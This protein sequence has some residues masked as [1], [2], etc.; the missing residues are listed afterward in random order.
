MK[1]YLK[2]YSKLLQ[3]NLSALLS[4][5]ANFINSMI[6]SIGWGT[7][8]FVSVLLLTSRVN[9]VYGWTRS[10][11]LILSA[12]YN[13]VIGLFHIFFSRNFERFSTVIHYGFLDSILLKPMDSQFLLSFWLVN[14]IGFFR[15][16]VGGIGI[17][18][19]LIYISHIVIT[20]AGIIGF[21]LF[22]ILGVITLY[23]IWYIFSTVIIWQS[24]LSNI[25]GLLYELNGVT[26]YPQE[27]YKGVS[28]ALYILV[29]PLSLVVTIPVKALIH[30]LTLIESIQI[31]C[32]GGALLFI[33]RR[34]WKF[35][36]RFYTSASG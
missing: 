28:T 6:S 18:I 24:R 36:L 20:F 30:K 16:L 15:I 10:E 22:M 32:L 27:F 19:Y 21:V 25:I 8:T 31:I 2:V 13:I 34:F 23:S 7:F 26:R 9:S 1:K 4:Y 29:L 14:Y 5:R 3:L 33:S 17:L 12:S 35:A 11:I